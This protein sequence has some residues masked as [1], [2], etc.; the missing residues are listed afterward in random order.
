MKT[1]VLALAGL[2]LVPAALAQQCICKSNAIE[3]AWC[4]M[5]K[6][7]VVSGVKITNEKLFAAL[8]GKEM[9]AEEV[10]KHCKGCATAM[11]DNGSCTACKAWFQGGKMYT[12]ALAANIAAGEVLTD[13]KIAG[14]PCA[15][16]KKSLEGADKAK[17]SEFA[18]YCEPCKG[19]VVAGRCY[20]GKDVYDHAKAAVAILVKASMAAAKCEGCALAMINDGKCDHCKVSFKDGK[21]STTTGTGM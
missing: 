8:Q 21:M 6:D 12:S 7:G 11:K 2:V 18:H 3:Q 20:K 9:K 17:W 15:D 16:C 5:C 10:A 14:C 4:A 19:G 1:L 13:E